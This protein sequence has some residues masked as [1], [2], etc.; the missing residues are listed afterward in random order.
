MKKITSL[1][2]I[3]SL[4]ALSAIASEVTNKRD[5]IAPW[6]LAQKP[7]Y[8]IAFEK[9]ADTLVVSSDYMNFGTVEL[10]LRRIEDE[11]VSLRKSYSEEWRPSITDLELTKSLLQ[12]DETGAV[13]AEVIFLPATTTI[14]IALLGPTKLLVHGVNTKKDLKLIKSLIEN[15]NMAVE[16]SDAQFIRLIRLLSR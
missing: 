6:Q 8:K 7:A 5:T 2:I 1:S 4:F 13:G 16:V 11:L 3:M 15:E 10:N 12:G 14:D 9:N